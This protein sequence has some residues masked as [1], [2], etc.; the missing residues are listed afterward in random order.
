M[1]YIG[2]HQEQVVET[3]GLDKVRADVHTREQDNGV[4]DDKGGHHAGESI[5]VATHGGELQLVLDDY[6]RVLCLW[7]AAMSFGL[8]FQVKVSKNLL[9]GDEIVVVIDGC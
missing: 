5:L 4:Q 9:C 8:I 3:E 6:R 7:V 1:T 2:E